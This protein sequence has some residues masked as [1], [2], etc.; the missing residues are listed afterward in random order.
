M[1]RLQPGQMSVDAMSVIV[2]MFHE[3][4][5]YMIQLLEQ[6]SCGFIYIIHVVE[7]QKGVLPHCHML[8]R[9]NRI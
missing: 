5:R 7:F 9:L 6:A 8:I 1:E 4:M 3:S 2:G